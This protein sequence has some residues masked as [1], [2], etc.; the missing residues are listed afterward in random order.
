MD[1]L[2]K[3]L[4]EKDRAGLESVLGQT[5]ANRM[6]NADDIGGIDTKKLKPGDLIKITTSR[7]KYEIVILEVE[8]GYAEKI[9]ISGGNLKNPEVGYLA[10]STYGGSMIK[11]HW[12]GLS[13]YLEVSFPNMEILRSSMIEQVEVI[14]A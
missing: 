3:Q 5:V 9:E 12:I 2:K 8:K 7:S 13:M 4:S 11:P 10:G 6:I 14:E 1:I